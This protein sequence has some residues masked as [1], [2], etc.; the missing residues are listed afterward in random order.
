MNVPISEETQIVYLEAFLGMTDEIAR[1]ATDR[2]IAEWAEASK[3]PTI[4][5]IKQRAGGDPKLLA[6]QAWE[7]MQLLIGFWYADG[8][9]WQ[10]GTDRLL[11][12]AMQYALRQC[13][14]EYRMAYPTDESAPFI[15]RDFIAAHERYQ[16]EDGAQVALTKGEA[17]E[18]LKFM[19]GGKMLKIRGIE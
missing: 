7:V 15:R 12:P 18:F 1:L 10:R 4:A 8:I 5:F 17:S 13:G 2:T 14:G 16:T 19:G 6:E 3:M 9:G 11:T